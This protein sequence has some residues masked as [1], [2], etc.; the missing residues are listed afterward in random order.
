VIKPAAPKIFAYLNISFAGIFAFSERVMVGECADINLLSAVDC[1]EIADANPD[2]VV[3]IKVRV[4]M[5]AGGASG[6]A[7]LDVA[8]EV[9]EEANLPVMCHLDT[10]PPSRLDVVNR[11][12]PGDVLTHCFRPFPGGPARRDGRIHEEVATAR[13]R[14][15]L[16]DIGHGK[17]SFG[18][19]TAES[20]LA[21]GFLPDCISS[22]VHIL[23]EKGPAHDL[24]VTMSKLMHL[25]MTLPEVIAAATTGP[26]KAIRHPELGSLAVGSTGDASILSLRNGP[27]TFTDSN[28]ETRQS[29]QRL[30]V[31]GMIINGQWWH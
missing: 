5:G 24:L 27:I 23:S 2:L 10:P 26:A 6:I 22:D 18:F 30:D 19:V 3:G 13:D 8:L 14:G 11:L 17:G 29:E 21:A 7:P 9:A 15:V 16:F 1:L 4:G 31:E 12:R 20:M 28:N 25:G